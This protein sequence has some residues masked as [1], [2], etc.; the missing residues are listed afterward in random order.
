MDENIIQPLSYYV[1]DTG[2]PAHEYTQ[3]K[4]TE[5]GNLQLKQNIQNMTSGALA[6]II[7]IVNPVLGTIFSAGLI[8]YAIETNINAQAI[9]FMRKRDGIIKL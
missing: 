9:F 8:L 5:Q 3:Y 2:Y 4:G 7:S 6:I 1:S